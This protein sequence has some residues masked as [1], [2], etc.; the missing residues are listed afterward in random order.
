M[1]QQALEAD[2][3]LNRVCEQVERLEEVH[4]EREQVVRLVLPP[5]IERSLNNSQILG[6]FRTINDKPD[7]HTS[8]NFDKTNDTRKKHTN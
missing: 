1:S 5:L 4:R 3:V 2:K 7:L 6:E 8:Y